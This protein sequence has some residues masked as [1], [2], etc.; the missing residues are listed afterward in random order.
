LYNGTTLQ[1]SFKGQ[2][3]SFTFPQ[4]DD[5]QKKVSKVK[6]SAYFFSSKTG[7]TFLVLLAGNLCWELATV[8]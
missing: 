5:K 1:V 8:P 2:T 6:K 7:G 3:V 4:A